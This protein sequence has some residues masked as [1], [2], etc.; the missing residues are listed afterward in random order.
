MTTSSTLG[1]SLAHLALESLE[2]GAMGGLAWPTLIS[3]R[4]AG[5]QTKTGCLEIFRPIEGYTLI[6]SYETQP[7]AGEATMR[8]LTIEDLDVKGKKVLMRVD[9]NVPL[10][11][12]KVA[13]D[14]RIRA[15]LP[16]IQYILGKGG[17]LVLMSHLGRPDGK[18][19]D[20]MSMRPC[21]EVPGK[22]A[23]PQGFFRGRLRRGDSRGGRGER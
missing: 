9:F 7:A 17:R 2:V 1:R 8:K 14:T 15:A 18:R 4:A 10:K 12:G 19:V 6:S 21:L 22:H 3:H 23:R 5:S 16:T 20:E 13:D 11:G